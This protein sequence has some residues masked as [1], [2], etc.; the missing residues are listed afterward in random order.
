MKKADQK[1]GI[2][3]YFFIEGMMKSLGEYFFKK[4]QLKTLNYSLKML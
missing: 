1:Q 3:I 2:F 4:N